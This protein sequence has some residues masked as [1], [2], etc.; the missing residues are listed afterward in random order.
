MRCK[1]CQTDGHSQMSD[2]YIYDACAQCVERIMAD[3]SDFG[4]SQ[5]NKQ[6]DALWYHSLDINNNPFSIFFRYD[7]NK[8]I[9]VRNNEEVVVLER[10]MP[11]NDEFLNSARDKIKL[12]QV[13]S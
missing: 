1:V 7:Q 11:L 6:M 10:I 2:K 9:F 5:I 12:W 8:T 3:K 13:F 4:F